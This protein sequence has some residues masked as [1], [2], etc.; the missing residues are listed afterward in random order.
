VTGNLKIVISRWKS[1]NVQTCII[2]LKPHSTQIRTFD[3]AVFQ[4]PSKDLGAGLRYPLT[5]YWD[6]GRICW[7]AIQTVNID[8]WLVARHQLGQLRQKATFCQHEWIMTRTSNW[9]NPSGVTTGWN[10]IQCL[11]CPLYAARWKRIGT[12]FT[13]S[14]IDKAPHHV[15]CIALIKHQFWIQCKIMLKYYWIWQKR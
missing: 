9:V 1:R 5:M 15:C 12:S 2:S 3:M 4:F 6:C 14:A 10:L 11:L 7:I 8:S 13:K